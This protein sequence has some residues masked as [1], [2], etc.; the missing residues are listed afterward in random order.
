MAN[1]TV[2]FLQIDVLDRISGSKLDYKILESIMKDVITTKAINGSECKILDLA[3]NIEVD[4]IDPKI[5]LDIFDDQHYLFGR[6]CKKKSNNAILQRDYSS[7]EP[8]EVFTPAEARRKGIEVFTFFMIDY[9]KG[10]ISIANAQDAPGA[11]ILNNILDNYNS[12]YIMKFTNIP[13]QDGINLLYRSTSPEI[14][15]LE[16]E[17]PSPDPQYLQRILKLDEEEI[18]YIASSDM[19]TTTL[20]LKPSPYKSLEKDQGKVRRII[21]I[22]KEKNNNY[23]HTII[24]GKSNEFGNKEFDLHAKYFTYPIKIKKYRIV[25]GKKKEYNLK[26]I[27]EQFKDGL[28]QAYYANKELLIALANRED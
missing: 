15:R 6:I 12:D 13:N 9:T 21:E 4:S 7:L 28:N 11:N 1:K 22:L 14:T 2:E 17:V 8:T 18:T 3:P 25:D 16:F 20:T 19:I 5:V 24:R 23:K 27:T 26:E 10:I